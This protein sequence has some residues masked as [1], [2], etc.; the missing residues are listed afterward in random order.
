MCLSGREDVD[1]PQTLTANHHCT[2]YRGYYYHT[3]LNAGKK[4]QLAAMLAGWRV[5]SDLLMCFAAMEEKKNPD[6]GKEV[7]KN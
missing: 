4:R 1:L 7:K 6:I 5:F 3:W 2:P